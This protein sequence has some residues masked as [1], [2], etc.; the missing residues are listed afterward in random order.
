MPCRPLPFLRFGKFLS[1]RVKAALSLDAGV[2][3]I[4]GDLVAGRIAA[5]ADD[6]DVAFLAHGRVGARRVLA[7]QLDL[8]NVGLEV[9]QHKISVNDGL[10]LFKQRVA[11][12]GIVG[13]DLALLLVAVDGH[14][15]F[16]HDVAFLFNIGRKLRAVLFQVLMLREYSHILQYLMNLEK[17]MKAILSISLNCL[18]V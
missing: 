14:R 2:M 16:A 13:A 5:V 10:Q 7:P 8:H 6:L 17:N 3:H 11:L 9:V 1:R 4:E 12:L 15:R 18:P